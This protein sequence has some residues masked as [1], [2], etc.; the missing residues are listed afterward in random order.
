L[1]KVHLTPARGKRK[2]REPNPQRGKRKLGNRHLKKKKKVTVHKGGQ[3]M[4]SDGGKK[5]GRLARSHSLQEHSMIGDGKT[6]KKEKL[7]PP[8]S[9]SGIKTAP[10]GGGW[11]GER[12]LGREWNYSVRKTG[13]RDKGLGEGHGRK[14]LGGMRVKKK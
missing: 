14:D 9:H 3:T 13:G 12:K 7:D 1:T 5:K 10:G 6:Q 8:F 2:E 4:D 11:G